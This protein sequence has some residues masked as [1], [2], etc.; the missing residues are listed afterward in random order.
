[1]EKDQAGACGAAATTLHDGRPACRAEADVHRLAGLSCIDCH[2]HTDLMGDGHE[3]EHEEEQVEITCEA[4]H[5][6]VRE[7]SAGTR[8]RGAR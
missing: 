3:W 8:R 7:G 2:L 4:C 6:P 1:M 5:G